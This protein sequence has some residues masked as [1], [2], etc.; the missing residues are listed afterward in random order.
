MA[1]TI[2]EAEERIRELRE[3]S[4]RT[5]KMVPAAKAEWLECCLDCGDQYLE[6]EMSL[7]D[8]EDETYFW[9]QSSAECWGYIEV[10][11]HWFISEDLIYMDEEGHWRGSG[12]EWIVWAAA[13]DDVTEFHELM[14]QYCI[15]HNLPVPQWYSEQT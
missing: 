10:Y 11:P 7:E 1:F 4:Q 15:T 14:H 3:Y 8:L 9:A 13:G 5:S 6:G 12:Y 2:E